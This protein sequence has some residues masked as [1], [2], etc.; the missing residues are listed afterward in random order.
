MTQKTT[1]ATFISN[2]KLDI[3]T[4][5]PEPSPFARLLNQAIDHN[6]NTYTAVAA[7]FIEIAPGL[8]M[9]LYIKIN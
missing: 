4:D 3:P 2:N 7:E 5:F 6:N 9:K 8:R 1:L